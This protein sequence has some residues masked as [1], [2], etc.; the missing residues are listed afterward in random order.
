MLQKEIELQKEVHR[1]SK[2]EEEY[3]RQKSRTLWLHSGDKNTSF[4][5][6]KAE[7]RKNFKSVSEIHH[8]NTVIKDFERI[9]RAAYS[10][11][12]D[13]YSAPEEP[14]I[15]PH[16]YLIDLIPNCVQDSDNAKLTTPISMDELKDVLD[17]MEP[18]KAP[19]PDGFSVR[20]LLTCWST[21]KKY[22]LRMARKSQNC[23][24]LGGD[25]NSAFLAL[26]P[27]EKGASDFSRFR[28]ISLCNSSYKLVS[29]IIANR[30][31]NILPDIIPENQGGFIKGRNI[32]DNIVLVQEAV[33]SSCQRNEKEARIL[34]SLHKLGK[35]CIASPWIAPL[36]NGRS[37]NFF[38]ASRGLRQ[39][40]PL[41]LLLYAIQASV[42][43]F[44]LEHNQQNHTLPGLRT[45][46]KVKDIN[47]AQFADDTLLLGGASLLSARHFKRE[48]DIY[49]SISG[50]KI[51]YRKC[52]IYGWN[53]SAKELADIARLL[54]M[55]GNR[56]WESFKYLG[57]PIFKAKP[58]VAHWL[59]LLDKI[60]NRIQAW[61]A[62]WLNNAGKV[63]LM[64]SV[65]LSMPLYQNS[66]ILAPKSF[67]SKLD[68]LLRR[69]LWEGGNNNDRRIHLV[70]WEI[71]KRPFLVGGLQLRNLAAQNLALGS[72]ILWN[73][74]SGKASW[75]KR[76]LWKKYFQGQ[77]LRC[78]DKPP[79]LLKGS[80]IF[81]ICNA[82]REQF[83]HYLY[84][85]P[86]NGK[87]IN[88]WDDSILGEQP[89]NQVEGLANIKGLLHSC[90]LHTLWD[91]S[92]WK[93]APDRT[94]DGW[95]L[96][97]VPTMMQGEASHLLD[98]LQGKSPSKA[99]SKDK[100]G[101]GSLSGSYS[102]AEGYKRFIVVPHAPP[103]PAQWKFIWDF[104]SLP[105]IDFFCWTDAHQSI[106]TRDNLRRR[107]MEGPSRC[108]LCLSDAETVSHLLLLCPFAQEV[109]KGV[110]KLD[111]AN[112]DLPDSIPSLFRSWARFS[113]FSF[114]KKSLLK[115]CWM[116]I[117][118]FTCWKLWLERN[119]IIFREEKSNTVRVISKIK[120][121]LGEALEA[122]VSS[123]NDLS[124]SKDE[125]QR[126]KELIPNLIE[127]PI[128]PASGHA[129]WEIRLEESEFIKWRSALDDH[130][131]FFD[132]ASKGNP[133]IA[134]SGGVLLNPGGFTEM[135]FHWGLGIETNNRAEALALW[136]GLNLAIN[137]NIL[138]LNVFGDSRLI[139]Q[140]L[141]FPKT[142]HQVHL[143]SIIKK[144]RLLLPK[145]NKIAFYHILRTLNGQAD[146]E[147]NMGSLCSQRSLVINSTASSSAIL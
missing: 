44:Q 103:N 31:K 37:T 51:N 47:H 69:F 136:Q 137:K 59:P 50:S 5:H 132:G 52:S 32:L 133:G 139:I 39:G 142:P 45:T 11:Y 57:I 53:C 9:K 3:W 129:N 48:L 89:L 120:A 73:L 140:A 27:K 101:W 104:P 92:K 13:L 100:R 74:V 124:L 29:K 96:G 76:V 25:I 4:F 88:I 14:A 84:W 141:L 127:R 58:K 38:Q 35:A 122:N 79:R 28:P 60:K 144:I 19:G 64:K 109:W 1:S 43:S 119:N 143:A 126:L 95:N 42:L 15:D 90:N 135:R 30:L 6:K 26:I 75:S 24:K 114:N 70:N 107:G 116:W 87:K 56:T 80:P 99:T 62:S 78:L 81:N 68:S 61:G 131:L 2:E 105:K 17:S 8:Q 106:L 146:L 134:G 16:V 93:E 91:I 65:L 54:E 63:T 112:L 67:L 113:P 117:P 102:V 97:E 34:N 98:L 123:R 83:I 10:F 55:D 72:K 138:S 77:R 7:A 110:L 108:P 111:P 147:P 121:L 23:A 40:C 46:H 130:C 20:F 94:W 41:S 36:V 18:D 66:I 21:I 115:T 71:L 86:G 12:Q 33:H 128:L 22:L 82:A 125:E 85:I 145:F 49:R 118:K